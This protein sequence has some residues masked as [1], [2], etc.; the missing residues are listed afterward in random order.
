[1]TYMEHG[2]WEILDVLRR[3]YRGES[4]VK[5]SNSTKRGRNTVKRYIH[6]AEGLG[7][8][9]SEEP[10]ETI[11]S[12][13]LQL[14]RPGRPQ[15]RPG[16]IEIK[17]KPHQKRILEWLSPADGKRG[18]KLTKVH[19]LL[20]RDG[21][22]VRYEA[23]SRFAKKHC[24][25]RQAKVTVRMAE[26]EPGE[27]AE[28]DFGKLGPVYDNLTGKNKIAHALLVTLPYSRHQYVHISFFQ[29]L[30]DL[31]CALENAWFFF[32]RHNVEIGDR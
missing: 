9:Q 26:T 2:M 13:V 30:P 28:V 4:K 19:Q 31:I 16:D 10:T 27:I 20:E 8:L 22:F 18:L 15:N 25:F 3:Y 12:A 29:K 32:W 21:I 23:L 7:W 6:T 24:D 17:L 11:A 5:I 1:M 14:L